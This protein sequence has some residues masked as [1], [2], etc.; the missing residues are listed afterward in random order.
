MQTMMRLSSRFVSI[1][2][3]A[4]RHR[5]LANTH[6]VRHDLGMISF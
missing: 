1:K 6:L 4:T 5:S 2:E 3:V